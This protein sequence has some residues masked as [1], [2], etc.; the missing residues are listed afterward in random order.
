MKIHLYGNTLNNSYYLATFLRACG[1]DAE[2]FLDDSSSLQ[3]DYPWWE[4]SHLN[5]HNLPSWIHYYRVNPN[6]MFPQPKLKE[7]INHFSKCDIALVCGWGP[8]I[9]KRAGVPYLF[10]SFGGD[11]TVTAFYENIREAFRKM[12]SFKKPSGLRSLLLYSHYQREAIRQADRVGILMAFQI[13]PYAR[14]LGVVEKMKLLRLAWD[15]EKYK[16]SPDPALNEKYK[17]YDIV[18]FMIARHSWKSVWNDM[19]GNDKFLKAYARFVKEKNP[20]VLLVTIDKGVDTDASK[21]LLREFG[22]EHAVEWVKEMNKDRIRAYISMSNVVVV[23][24][25]WHDN[26]RRRYPRN[27]TPAFG[28]GSAGIEAM[29]A[30]AVLIT[31]FFHED[32]YEGNKP[33][34]LNAFTEEEIYQRL[35]QSLSMTPDE[36]AELGKK[37]RAF[38]EKYH[39]WKNVVPMYV[40][41]LE[42]IL[43]ERHRKKLHS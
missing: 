19:K 13:E 29:C 4:D 25:F 27:E 37:A 42:E 2:M 22:V 15:I 8:I 30:E 39:G 31:G 11:L 21:E 5:E 12:A 38:V 32:F 43:E 10:Y 6:F 24:Q 35:V 20:N 3:Q 26:W 7:M 23:D 14:K 16:K 17:N 9:A 34:I 28:L 1:Y 36:R 33:P 18:Y 41:V 40:E